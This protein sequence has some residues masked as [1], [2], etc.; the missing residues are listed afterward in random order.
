MA[1]IPGLHIF[2]GAPPMSDDLWAT[3][4]KVFYVGSTAAP[5]GV[6]GNDSAGGYGESPLQPF[7]TLDYA[8]GQCT[9]SRGDTIV[10]LPGHAETVTAAVTVDVAGI[11][12]IGLG[13]GRNRPA[14][15]ASGVIDCMTITADNCRVHNL[16][17]PGVAASVTAQIN[18]NAADVVISRCVIEQAAI[19]LIAMTVVAGS[20][21]LT[22]KDCLFRGTADG[23]D[24][25]IDF[26]GGGC[27]GF[28]CTGNI[29]NYSPSGID[30]ACIRANAFSVNSGLIENCRFIS[31]VAPFIDFNCSDSLSGDGLIANVVA[32]MGP[33]TTPA[34]VDTCID[35]GGY[36]NVNVLVCK[37]VTDSGSRIPVATGA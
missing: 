35:Q 1:N 13:E 25:A 14:I 36:V 22:V 27:D 32:S 20:A 29:F 3:T 17:F 26:E 2:G 9:A 30:T 6:T 4:G 23:A 5:G 8:I 16:R 15:T 7:A 34:D 10:V 11:R 24:Y 37:A 33:T 18:V 21:R 19:P 31:V 12:I 28:T